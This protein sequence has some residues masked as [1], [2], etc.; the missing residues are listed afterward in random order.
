MAASKDYIFHN[1]EMS[2]KLEKMVNN[3]K[4]SDAIFLVN[5][6]QFHASKHVIIASS[7]VFESLVDE[8]YRLMSERRSSNN[9]IK[10]IDVK[11][12]ESFL[13]ILRYLYGASINFTKMNK[14]VMCEVLYLC[15]RYKLTVFSKELQTFLSNLTD[16]H[17]E[18]AVSLLSY[19]QKYNAKALYDKLI[20]FV[21]I[22]A[23]QMVKHEFH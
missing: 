17:L 9:S 4:Y 21:Y 2:Q 20:S 7:E 14:T 1:S 8:H 15:E 23:D 6:A 19:A 22:K 18:S 12:D 13:V 3:K 16:F 11:N 10:I 5:N